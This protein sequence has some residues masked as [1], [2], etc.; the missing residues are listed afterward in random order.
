MTKREKYLTA[1]RNEPVDELLWVPNFDYWLAVNTAEDTLPPK[2]RGMSRNDIVRSIGAIIWNR[3]AGLKPVVD[4]EVKDH[5]RDENDLRIHEVS[6]PV[7]NVREVYS[8]AEGPA[9]SRALTE[10]FVKDLDSLRVMKFMV[11]ATHFEPNY[12]PT[13]QALR[14]TGDDGIVLNPAFCVPFIQFAKTDIGYNNAFFMWSDQREA[15]DELIAL[16][17]RKFLEGY[18]VLADGPADVIATG[19]NMDGIMISPSIFKEYAIPFYQE[20]KKLCAAKGKIFEGHWCGRTQS[21]LSRV[22][23][24]GL[25]V[26]E[27]I[28]TEPMA[29]IS[30]VEALGRLKGQVVLQGGLPAVLVCEEGGTRAEFEKYVREVIQPLRGRRGFV[31]GMADNVPPNADFA[32]VEAVAGLIA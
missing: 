27:A 13:R 22:P 5:W 26:I 18:R 1:L 10:H 30:L 28:V 8:Q 20:S 32:R 25:D 14:E 23:G 19:D 12:E 2:Y 3:A 7:G 6:T 11:E 9:R 16:Y 31:I 15:V 21:L 17:H 24:C 29:E 4:P